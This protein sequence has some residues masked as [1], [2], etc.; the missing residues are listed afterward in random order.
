MS[1]VHNPY[2]HIGS[3]YGPAGLLIMLS[4]FL[5][6][7]F[8]GFKNYKRGLDNDGFQFLTFWFIALTFLAQATPWFQAESEHVFL[9]GIAAAHI[10]IIEL[11][12][13]LKKYAGNRI[14]NRLGIFAS[15]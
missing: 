8:V 5:T 6:T 11:R 13:Q 7:S 9:S 12:V 2:L 10:W 14:F 15:S 3:G 1:S 4:F